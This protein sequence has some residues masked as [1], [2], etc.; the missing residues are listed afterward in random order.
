MPTR[1]DKMM[2]V[3]RE[4]CRGLSSSVVSR[5]VLVEVDVEPIKAVEVVEVIDF[6]QVRQHANCWLDHYSFLKKQWSPLCIHSSEEY[7][8]LLQ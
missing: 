8:W 2:Y 7:C 1:K 3:E 5:F 6:F 4:T